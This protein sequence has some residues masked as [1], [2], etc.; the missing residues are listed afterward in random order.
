M[1]N[2]R[3]QS[4]SKQIKS[5]LKAGDRTP[6]SIAL[7]DEVIIS[8]KKKKKRKEMTHGLTKL[9]FGF[10]LFQKGM[11]RVSSTEGEE[12]EGSMRGRKWGLS[13]YFISH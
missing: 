9:T 3:K 10:F 2:W 13:S 8:K 5:P 7:T 4:R 11:M 12:E 1:G 6:Q